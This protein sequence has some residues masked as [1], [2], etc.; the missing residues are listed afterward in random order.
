MCDAVCRFQEKYNISI[1]WT[2]FAPEHGKGV[3]DGIVA[4]LKIKARRLVLA[5]RCR[6]SNATDFVNAV[7]GTAIQVTHM[8]KDDMARKN[9]MLQYDEILK[10][11]AIPGIT[12]NF[13]FTF[14][15]NVTKPYIT[16][17]Q[18]LAN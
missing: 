9:E 18:H 5:N 2:Y 3:V 11:K 13:Y 10:A 15:N 7:S 16:Y 14:D 4:T 6:I 17:K 12:K 1:D 8:S